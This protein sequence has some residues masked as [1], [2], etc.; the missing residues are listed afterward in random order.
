MAKPNLKR[1]QRELEAVLGE[2]LRRRE[3][4]VAAFLVETGLPLRRIE[5]V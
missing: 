5:V 2:G 4:L 1:T 3:M